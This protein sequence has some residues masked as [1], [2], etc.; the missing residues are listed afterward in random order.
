MR[1]LTLILAGLVLVAGPGCAPGPSTP[2]AAIP[3]EHAGPPPPDVAVLIV[4]AGGE[5]S[6]ELLRRAA[7]EDGTG[8]L[9]LAEPRFSDDDF[10]GCLAI[11][12][13]EA[14]IRARLAGREARAMEGPP[15]V[16]VL[17]RPGPGFLIGWTCVGVGEAPTVAA[18][19]NVSL[20]WQPA[21]IE[22]SA[23]AAARCIL[24]AAAESG[25]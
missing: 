11:A 17:L 24:A 13:S 4:P 25:W 21:Q 3:A 8:L 10:E 6:A 22:A 16:V 7:P 12:E 20:D 18:R 2:Q 15:T 23:N 9:R 14:C 19:Q 5:K 1:R